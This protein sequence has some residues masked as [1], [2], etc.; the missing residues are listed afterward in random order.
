MK[1]LELAEA[2]ASLS[3]YTKRLD[4]E[5]LILTKNGEPVA[6]LVALKD[7]DLETLLLAMNSR[8]SDIIERSR[9]RLK[10][11]GGISSEEMRQRLGLA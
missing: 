8:F 6:A 9:T 1:T 2:T 4:N 10:K 3:E 5:P 11:E 7:N